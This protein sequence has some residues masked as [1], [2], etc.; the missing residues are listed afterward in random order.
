MDVSATTPVGVLAVGAGVVLIW[1]GFTG[2]NPLTELRSVLTTGKGTGTRRP[3]DAAALTGTQSAAIAA[4]WDAVP[5]FGG[6]GG[7]SSDPGNFPRHNPLMLVTVAP[8]GHKLMPAAATAFR[9]AEQLYG[10]SLPLVGSTRT[11]EDQ[12]ANYRRDPGRFGPPDGNAHVAGMAVDINLPALGIRRGTDDEPAYMK[13]VRA[14]ESAGWCNFQRNG[15]MG[16]K[17]VKEPHHWSF[18]GCR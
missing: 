13:L 3:L 1:S 18:G 4:G 6:S 2:Q 14:M 11:Y 17:N 12:A 16:G 8:G 7:G 9:R 10:R 15:S 5:S